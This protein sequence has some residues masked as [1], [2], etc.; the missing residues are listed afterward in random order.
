VGPGSERKEEEREREKKQN[1]N[2]N[3]VGV[4]AARAAGGLGN[5]GGARFRG[6]DGVPAAIC[7][8][9]W[10][11][12]ALCWRGFGLGVLLV[13]SVR[14]RGVPGDLAEKSSGGCPVRARLSEK[15]RTPSIERKR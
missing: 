3:N 13:V 14:S 10:R 2:N 8:V 12:G 6:D 9:V 7:V 11:C 5:L 4:V 15:G 1:S